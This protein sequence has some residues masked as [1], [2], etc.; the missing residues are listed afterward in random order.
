MSGVLTVKKNDFFLISILILL[1]IVFVFISLYFNFAAPVLLLAVIF[2]ASFLIYPHIGISLL[3]AA[4]YFILTSTEEI[5]LNEIG[6]GGLIGIV[7]LFWIVREFT[8]VKSF[9]K[10]SIK[11]YSL[12]FLFGAAVFSII[13]A[14][15]YG[16][17]LMKWFRELIPF[18][19]L[20]LFYP[21][22]EA[23]RSK[24]IIILFFLS[25]LV[26]AAI[27]SINNVL[28]YREMM[29]NLT[30][31]WQITTSRQAFNESILLTAFVLCFTGMIY[32][33][34]IYL[35]FL[36]LVLSI[37]F[38]GS[39]IISFSRAYWFGALL[40]VVVVFF[41]VELRY[42]IRLIWISVASLVMLFLLFY[43]LFHDLTV[44]IFESVFS[45]FGTLGNLGVDISLLNRLEEY[46]ALLS[47]ILKNPVTGYGLGAEFSY[48]N[49]IINSDFQFWY[50]HNGYFYLIYKLGLAGFIFFFWFYFSHIKIGIRV[51]LKT[52]DRFYKAVLSGFLAVMISYLIV[53]LTSPQFYQ[54]N[55][56]LI[57]A[58]GTAIISK[59]YQNDSK[60]PI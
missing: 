30:K 3:I 25:F 32:I 8:S 54:K 24:K 58:I 22:R 59:L 1:H 11:D 10:Y 2:L 56:L 53:S 55:S 43:F 23:I 57:L 17:N 5:T 39:L 19:I 60:R 45:R 37:A 47:V 15:F 42:K 46:K 20:L 41:I 52:T 18:I 31:E 50:T 27:I 49:I 26:L 16:S 35:K 36:F 44:K 29:I 21:I 38:F 40:A 28:N 4:H 6:I 9:E 14:I 12:I 34:R 48:F 7:I 51:F 33:K 13:P